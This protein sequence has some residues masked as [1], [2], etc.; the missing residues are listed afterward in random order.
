M[1]TDGTVVRWKVLV[2][3]GSRMF[4]IVVVVVNPSRAMCLRSSCRELH[5]GYSGGQLHGC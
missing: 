4:A 3:K 5:D 1:C 2:V